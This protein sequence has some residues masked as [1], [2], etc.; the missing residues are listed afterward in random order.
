MILLFLFIGVILFVAGFI[1]LNTSWQRW[2]IGGIGLLILVGSITLMIGNDISNWGMTQHTTQTTAKIA[3][4]SSQKQLSLLVYEPIRKA[5]TER[6]YI[7]RQPSGNRL[8]HTQPKLTVT[9]RV[10]YRSV[11]QATLTTNTKEWQLKH[12]GIWHFLFAGVAGEKK[13]ITKNNRF[14]LPTD[15]QILSRNQANWLAKQAKIKE[16]KAT[17]AGKRAITNAVRQARMKDPTISAKQA[18]NIDIEHQATKQVKVE[19][20][21]QEPKSMKQLIKQ[22][23]K[24]PVVIK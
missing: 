13:I 9:N 22:A 7:Y 17:V 23:K 15:W 2:L 14:L 24:Q 3:S 4:V 12:N 18:A 1:L 11:N 5:K 8:V 21:K 16:H 19:V 20:H 10:I 6:V